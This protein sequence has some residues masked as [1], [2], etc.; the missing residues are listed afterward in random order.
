M[1][2]KPKE[3]TM[4]PQLTQDDHHLLQKHREHRARIRQSP[5]FVTRVDRPSAADSGQTDSVHSHTLG[6]F[7]L[8]DVLLSTRYLPVELLRS[9]LVK[10][11]R[12][13]LQKGSKKKQKG[14]KSA[15]EHPSE[16]SGD[17]VPAVSPTGHAADDTDLGVKWDDLKMEEL[18]TRPEQVRSTRAQPE[19]EGDFR[20]DDD[21]D[22]DDDDKQKDADDDMEA[23]Y[24][25]G[26]EVDDDEDAFNAQEEGEGIEHSSTA[27]FT[28]IL[29]VQLTQLCTHSSQFRANADVG[30]TM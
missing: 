25:V 28:I 10:R 27:L 14:G 19:D 21:D 9:N 6:A 12:P 13:A 15:E 23:D 20:N 11:R 7:S 5:Y 22:D 2:I 18:A 3:I 30:P 8:G 17:S 26:T 1:T 29:H 16:K 24:M 4:P